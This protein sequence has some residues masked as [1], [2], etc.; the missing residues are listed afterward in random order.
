MVS[1]RQKS[2]DQ[3]KPSLAGESSEKA[4]SN[5]DQLSSMMA[6]DAAQ[7]AL[8]EN[9]ISGEHA[10]YARR[11][12]SEAAAR[13]MAG[14]DAVDLDS[15]IK[16]NDV[17]GFQGDNYPTYDISSRTEVASVKTHWNVEGKL[18]ASA[19]AAYKRDVALM[20]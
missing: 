20:P 15:Y 19:I 16:E 2:T 13:T 17:A 11:Y 14:E 7:K 9:D 18:N 4:Q 3:S 10:L 1:D 6:H 8:A 12:A 5:V